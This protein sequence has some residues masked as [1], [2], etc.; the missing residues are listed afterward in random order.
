LTPRESAIARAQVW[1]PRD[2]RSVD[3]KAGPR[4]PGAFPFLSTVDCR[5]GEA[6][7]GGRS[8]KFA[9][10]AAPDDELKVKYGGNNAEVYGEVAASRLLWALGF[11]ADRMYP[12]RV[13]CSGCPRELA[14]IARGGDSFVFDPA[15]IERRLPG[16]DFPGDDD[17]AWFELDAVDEDAG[18]APRAHVDA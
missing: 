9:C 4:H 11:G 5:Y 16:R 18:G 12:V 14:G 3:I 15:V 8:P 7:L 17:W 6:D 13:I 10:R 2:V 1:T